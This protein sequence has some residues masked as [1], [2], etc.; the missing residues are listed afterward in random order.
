LQILSNEIQA[1]KASLR[2]LEERFRTVKASHSGE[3]ASLNASLGAAADEVQTKQAMVAEY[4]AR[5]QSEHVNT[6]NRLASMNSMRSQMKALCGPADCQTQTC[7]LHDRC[8]N[9]CTYHGCCMRSTS[10]Y[11]LCSGQC[12]DQER[13]SEVA[14][15]A[16]AVQDLEADLRK[17][18]AMANQSLE[19]MSHLEQALSAEKDQ[20][21]MTLQQL[22][23]V[24]R[25]FKVQL[26]C[27]SEH[28]RS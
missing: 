12:R 19:K 13:N 18:R 6:D 26:Y 7:L 4:E 20:H 2:D 11:E 23:Q 28:V 14:H 27:A 3:L 21:Q 10:M 16:T 15:A 17:A 5:L 22:S 24:Q 1:A 8:A 25:Q 9:P